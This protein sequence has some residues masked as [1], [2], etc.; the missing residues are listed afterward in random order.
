MDWISEMVLKRNA[1]CSNCYILQSFDPKR[2]DEFRR[3]LQNGFGK[4]CK[5]EYKRILEYSIQ[6]NQIYAK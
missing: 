3:V 4:L 6:R 2:I 5:T 1:Q